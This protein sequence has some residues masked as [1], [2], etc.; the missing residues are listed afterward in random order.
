MNIV[1][2]TPYQISNE[3]SFI[4]IYKYKLNIFKY[5][6]FPTTHLKLWLHLSPVAA[7]L[8]FFIHKVLTIFYF[9]SYKIT[10][11]STYIFPGRATIASLPF[12]SVPL[13]TKIYLKHNYLFTHYGQRHHCGTIT[14][15]LNIIVM[16]LKIRNGK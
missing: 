7:F 16:I 9:G 4:V 3:T 2:I 1:N 10:C 5:F 13:S 15:V 6:T 8:N 14:E 12:N 11:F